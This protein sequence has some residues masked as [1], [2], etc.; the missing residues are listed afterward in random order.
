MVNLNLDNIP[1]AEQESLNKNLSANIPQE[2]EKDE[3]LAEW[4]KRTALAVVYT[5]PH[6]AYKLLVLLRQLLVPQAA[7]IK[8]KY[9]GVKTWLYYSALIDLSKEE[10]A[11]F[12]K[13]GNLGLILNQPG[14]NDLIVKVKCR[15]SLEALEDRDG[16]RERIYNALHD[17]VNNLSAENLPSGGPG[18]VANW[19]KFYDS[20]IG[21]DPAESLDVAQFISRATMEAKLSDDEKSV[22]RSFLDFYEFIKLTSYDARG[23]EED[24]IFTDDKGKDYLLAD[25][26]QIDLEQ[27]MNEYKVTAPVAPRPMGERAPAVSPAVLTGTSLPSLPDIIKQSQSYLLATNGGVPKVIAELQKSLS[28]GNVLGATGAL[29]LLAQLRRLDDVLSDE[30]AFRTLV[31]QDLEKSGQAVQ[32]EGLSAQPAAPQFLARFLK[33]ILQDNLH[34]KA[35]EA[36]AFVGRLGDLMALE[37]EAYRRLVLTNERGEKRWNT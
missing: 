30:P 26:Q 15:L 35:D 3:V 21:L 27:V 32:K 9:Q 24:I 11:A 36:M 12:F 33:I 2:I 1:L 6:F 13:E 25:G 8:L 31:A 19:L 37:G 34:I 5:K 14:H 7:A 16:W 17:N 4:E 23:F 18:T 29:V 10:L 20:Q 22:L 28:G